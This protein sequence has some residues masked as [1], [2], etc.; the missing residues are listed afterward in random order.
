ML[1][2]EKGL[3]DSLSDSSSALAKDYWQALIWF[4]SALSLA[5]DLLGRPNKVIHAD[6]FIWFSLSAGHMV[7]RSSPR[8]SRT[9]KGA[10][11]SRQWA[12][13]TIGRLM[14][15]LTKRLR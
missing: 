10:C 2:P 7:C 11:R 8:A 6:M 5:N 9:L 14:A 3:D 1:G 13:P 12:C 15:R 4:S